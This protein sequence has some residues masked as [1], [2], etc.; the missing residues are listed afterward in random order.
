MKTINFYFAKNLFYTFA[1]TLIVLSFVLLSA[2]LTKIFELIS[3]GIPAGKL[4]LY[5]FYL[6]PRVLGLTIPLALLA[7]TILLFSRMS[8][9]NEITAMRASG[10]SIW[11]IISPGLILSIILSAFCFYLQMHIIPHCRYKARVLICTKGIKHMEAFLEAGRF[12]EVFEGYIIYIG[13]RDGKNLKD[14]HI[15]G[16]DEEKKMK[17]DI[18]A[19]TGQIVTDEKSNL[20]KLI[21]HKATIVSLEPQEK[22]RRISGSD[23]TFLLNYKKKFGREPLTRKVKNMTIASLFAMIQLYRERHIDTTPLYV[24]IHKRLVLALSPFAFLLMGIPFGIKTQ[25]TETSAGLVISLVLGM[26]FYIFVM[27]AENMKHQGAWHPE[28]II[29]TPSILYQLGGIFGL[30]LISKR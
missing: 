11:Q 19:Q 24:N 16:L 9:D 8:A 7:A 20:L 29:W 27:L 14:I 4:F 22:I 13:E 10:I 25:R 17:K 23:F 3:K 12:I 21:L 1:V 2:N 18:V 5:V 30:N 28:I 15:Y 6:M 26:F